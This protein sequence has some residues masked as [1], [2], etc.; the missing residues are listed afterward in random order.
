[1]LASLL[2]VPYIF[3][4]SWAP[5][6]SQPQRVRQCYCF[7]LDYHHDAES[8][9][10][11]TPR[12]NLESV[13]KNDGYSTQNKAASFCVC[14][15]AGVAGLFSSQNTVAVSR[16]KEFCPVAFVGSSLLAPPQPLAVCAAAVGG[17][18][19]TPITTLSAGSDPKSAAGSSMST[20]PVT[21]AEV[22]L[23]CAPIALG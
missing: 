15:G 4:H 8:S 7:Y 23:E 17:P 21:N 14:C 16:A 11:D 6:P 1:M 22:A 19:T 20:L 12:K 5:C 10:S 9:G 18:A 2:S 13:T 3:R